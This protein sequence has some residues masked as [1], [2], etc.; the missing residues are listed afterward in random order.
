MTSRGCMLAR[1]SGQMLACSERCPFWEAGGA[2]LPAVCALER[3]QPE[4]EWTPEL[5]F[6]WRRLRDRLGDADARQPTSFFST[7]LG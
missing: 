2:V 7:L 6:R 3:I 1:R 5:A 4:C